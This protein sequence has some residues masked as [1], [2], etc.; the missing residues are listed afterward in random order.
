MYIKAHE[1]TAISTVAL[2]SLKVL[3][4]FVDD[5]YSIIKRMHLENFFNHIKNLHQNIKFIMEKERNGELLFLDILLKFNNRNIPAMVHGKPFNID[6][7]LYYTSHHQTSCK[8]SVISILFNRG[9][10]IINNE[11]NLTKE[12]TRIKQMLKNGY[13]EGIT[14]KTVK[15]IYNDHS[16]SQSQQKTKATDIQDEQIK[17]SINLWHI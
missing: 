14:S 16:L 1:Q 3:E 8:G 5:V 4:R 2:L 17:T 10:F 11:D 6:Q 13:H 9:Y 7:Y 15:K 12:N